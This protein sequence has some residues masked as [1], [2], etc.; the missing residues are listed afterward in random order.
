MGGAPA[1]QTLSSTLRYTNTAMKNGPGG[2]MYF[3]CK[4]RIFHCHVSLPDSTPLGTNISL[5]KAVLKMS[6][7]FPRW[8]MLIPWRV[9]KFQGDQRPNHPSLAFK[10]PDCG[11]K[12]PLE[13][14]WYKLQSDMTGP[15]ERLCLEKRKQRSPV[16]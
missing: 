1:S 9:L 10:E 8:D 3:P 15:I 13:R 14:P 11:T 6:F 7:V 2:K 4:M 12:F 5:S 16:K